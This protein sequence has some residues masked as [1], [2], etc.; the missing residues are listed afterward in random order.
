MKKLFFGAAAAA[1][2]N[3]AAPALAASYVFDFSGNSATVGF[4]GNSRSF[5]AT[6]GDTTLNVRASGWSIDGSTLKASYLG[7]YDNGLGVTSGDDFLGLGNTHAID[8][9]GRKDFVLLQF[10]QAVTLNSA[11]LNT[12]SVLGHTR[13]SDATI[14]WGTSLAPWNSSLALNNQSVNSLIALLG[15]SYTSLGTSTGGTRTLNATGGASNLWL[16]A[17][18]ITNA[19][20]K[21]DGFKLE[22]LGVTYTPVVTPAVPEPGSW[23]MMIAGFGLVGGAMRRRSD[24]TALTLA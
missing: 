5:S 18:D 8:N 11:T 12:Y 4:A 17:A 9:H 14:A 10:D 22:K 7:A 24:Q 23:A 3:F 21:I 20:H 1:L 16:I 6:S 13:D 2:V 15:G 19:D